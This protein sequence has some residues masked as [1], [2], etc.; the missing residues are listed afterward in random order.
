MPAKAD[1]LIQL[2]GMKYTM[3]LL[4]QPQGWRYKA[5]A[6]L[7]S[8]FNLIPVLSQVRKA[9]SRRFTTRLFAAPYLDRSGLLYKRGFSRE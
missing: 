8:A 7:L 3:K 1:G 5:D 4:T 2:T 9:K 6:Q